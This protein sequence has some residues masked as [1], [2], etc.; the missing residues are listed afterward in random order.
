MKIRAGLDTGNFAYGIFVDFQKAFDTV[1]HEIPLKTLEHYGIRHTANK[2]FRSYLTN[3]TQYVSINGFDSTKK[4][5][6][7]GVPQ[8]SVLGP[9]LFLIYIIDLNKP[10]KNSITHHFADDTSLLY[11]GKSIKDIQERV[12]LDPRFLCMWLNARK[13]SLNFSKTKLLIFR[14]PR[15][16]INFDI[17]IKFDG[18]K[19]IPSKSVKYLG[20]HIGNHLSWHHFVIVNTG[21]NTRCERLNHLHTIA[22]ETIL[23]GT[24]SIMSQ[25]I[26]AWNS[27]NVELHDEI[28]QNKNKAVAKIKVFNL[29]LGKY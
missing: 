4:P 18:K 7:Y 8:G 24:R 12:N 11:A 20:I 28:L 23:Y 26:E 22:T 29:L 1:D 5:M 6:K 25:S 10:V 27:V 16:N 21:L 19:I 13:I 17:K 14:D 9:L 15:K 3:R 2:W